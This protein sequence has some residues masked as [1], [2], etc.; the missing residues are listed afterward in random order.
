MYEIADGLKHNIKTTEIVHSG[1]S[2]ARGS[3]KIAKGPNPSLVKG[4]NHS[5][6]KGPNPDVLIR[7]NNVSE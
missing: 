1:S 4:P 7:P 2:L 6:V 5:L 3:A